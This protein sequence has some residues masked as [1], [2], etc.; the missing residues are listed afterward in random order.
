MW[1]LGGLENRRKCES[2]VDS[3]GKVRVVA[4]GERTAVELDRVTLCDAPLFEKLSAS[5][6]TR[7]TRAYSCTMLASCCWRAYLAIELNGR[8]LAENSIFPLERVAAHNPLD[9]PG[10]RGHFSEQVRRARRSFVRMDAPAKIPVSPHAFTN[11]LSTQH[12]SV[13]VKQAHE[14]RPQGL[15][16]ARL[17]GDV[18]QMRGWMA[19][20]E[21]AHQL[22]RYDV[23]AY[24]KGLATVL[25]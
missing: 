7:V 18:L 4:E 21:R 14:S 25:V 1:F 22:V 9:H 20:V 16:L 23:A 6:L 19:R 3:P 5:T 15:W 12:L 17:V 11:L 8:S 10:L 24:V 2:L 13:V